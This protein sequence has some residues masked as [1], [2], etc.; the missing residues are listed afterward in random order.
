MSQTSQNRSK[1]LNGE[2]SKNNMFLN[3][4]STIVFK[5][6]LNLNAIMELS[7]HLSWSDSVVLARERCGGFCLNFDGYFSSEQATN[8]LIMKN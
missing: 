5:S 3:L 6:G 8:L 2:K 4:H 7:T 1:W